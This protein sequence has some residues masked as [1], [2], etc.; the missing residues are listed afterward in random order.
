MFK[1]LL[2]LHSFAH[3]YW[4]CCTL[5]KKHIWKHSYTSV[6]G[7]PS[8]S[9]PI[10]MVGES[11]WITSIGKWRTCVKARSCKIWKIK[12]KS[13]IKMN[14]KVQQ[15]TSLCIVQYMTVKEELTSSCP[16]Q[17][18]VCST[19]LQYFSNSSGSKRQTC[20]LNINKYSSESFTF[21]T[22]NTDGLT[23]C[24][25]VTCAWVGEERQEVVRMASHVLSSAGSQF[26][27]TCG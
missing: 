6:M 23:C 15:N 8:Y 19:S 7:S 18:D 17:A 27:H 16:P 12:K 9:S 21:I 14:W 2:Q 10:F 24:V 13:I 11:A 22:K 26:L 5:S 25:H 3:F 4:Q 20:Q 1:C